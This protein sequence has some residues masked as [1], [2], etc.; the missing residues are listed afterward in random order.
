MTFT[1]STTFAQTFASLAVA[2]NQLAV[3]WLGQ[4][5][6]A[7][8]GQAVQV[9][10]DPYLSNSL[11]ESAGWR[12]WFEPPL[13]P[14]EARPDV[15]VFTHDHQDHLDPGTVPELAR[16]SGAVFVGPQSCLDH[17]RELGVASERLIRLEAGESLE[18]CGVRLKATHAD[19]MHPWGPPVPDAISLELGFGT[20]RVL[21]AADTTLREEVLKE[22]AGLA[23]DILLV[24]INGRFGNMNGAD[25]AIYT[26]G[27][28][29][30]VV[31]PMHYGLF[32]ANTA[33]PSEFL[34]AVHAYAQDA[35][36][37]VMSYAEIWLYE[38]SK[39]E[40]GEL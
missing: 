7:F 3:A 18:V 36:V 16:H 37:K 4:G 14:D 22:V 26:Q 34:D 5:S 6:F 39:Y 12:R 21:N 27:V 32:S 35:H 33:D 11:E 25:A 30:R 31:V 20:L 15:V 2:E 17:A 13:R 1:P 29:P 38:P 8:K 19:H 24:P 23:P 9:Y 28:R 40:T 10:V